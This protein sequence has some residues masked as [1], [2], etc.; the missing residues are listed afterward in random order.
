MIITLTPNPSVERT[1]L[2]DR[3]KFNEILRAA[4]AQLEW[5]G[6]GIN[7][8]RGLRMFR[9]NSLAIA[10]LAEEQADA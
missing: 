5:S 8:S 7:V 6:K 9:Q 4:P 1:L 10:W 3:I 2:V